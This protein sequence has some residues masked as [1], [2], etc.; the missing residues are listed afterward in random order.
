[1]YIIKRVKFDVVTNDGTTA[2]VTL[3]DG[4]VFGGV[5]I[6]NNIYFENADFRASRR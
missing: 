3:G 4:A 1:M 6:R 5:S 2:F